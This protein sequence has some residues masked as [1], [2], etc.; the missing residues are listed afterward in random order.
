VITSFRVGAIFEIQDRATP[1]VDRLS[2]LM[3]ELGVATATVRTELQSISS[4]RIGSVTNRVSALAASMDKGGTAAAAMATAVVGG[5]ARM[6]ASLNTALG[7]ARAL[8]AQLTAAGRAGAGAGRGG[9]P[10]LPGPGG[11]GGGRHGPGPH[12]GRVGVHAGPGHVSAGGGD[13][14]ATGVGAWAVG[15]VLKESMDPMHQ[16]SQLRALGGD[17]LDPANLKAAMDRA[18]AT[19]TAVPGSGYAENLKTI[20]ELYSVVGLKGALALSPELAELDRVMALSGKGKEE[21]SG[22]ILTRASELMGQLTD[23]N[24]HEVDLPK[25]RN[26]LALAGKANLA[27]HG[28]VTPAEWLAFA[29][30][31]GPAAGSFTEEGF[32]TAVAVIQATSGNRA[33]TAMQAINRQFTGGKMNIDTAKELER[34][35]IAKPGD[36]EF[37]HGKVITKTGSMRTAV[38]QLQ[39][40]PLS[41]M[42]NTI[43]PALNAKGLTSVKDVQAEGYRMFG[44]GPAQR[45]MF[46]L[47]RGQ[48]QIK[49][50][51]A[52]AQAALAPG[53]A[54][55]SAQE[56]D[57]VQGMAAFT[58]AFNDMLGAIGGPTL[59][60]AIPGMNALTTLFNSVAAAASEH[61]QGAAIAGS[62]ASGAAAGAAI[63]LGIG[64]LGGPV[65]AG[66]G[67]LIGG[68]LGGLSGMIGSMSPQQRFGTL[69]GA[70]GGGAAGMVGGPIGMAFGALAGGALGAV[71]PG[72][73]P[74][75]QANAGQ[76]VKIDVGG[77]T[78]KA[79]T[80]DPRGLA[81]RIL[82]EINR[83]ISQGH[84]HNQGEAT[85]AA[86]SPYATGA[87]T[88]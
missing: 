9:A 63:G 4:V 74:S 60:A 29:K 84:L 49:Q 80:D 25:M 64:W 19:A 10:R 39:N 43:V 2:V 12:F 38:D 5:V 68:A 73:M 67:A 78:V 71:L 31:A 6:D 85:G 47:F 15:H 77:L 23:P 59:T 62:I 14:I 44:T 41:F 58:K 82:A 53:A 55:A 51:R 37:E 56:H 8:T 79:E 66:G 76:M 27:T 17:F 11:G 36:F 22:Y 87:V 69:S 32:L 45:L 54:F 86:S 88:P 52:R 57:P 75:G 34:L 13:A 72:L 61:K 40:D 21:G 33:G 24:T 20:G 48:E 18:R 3:R 42:V 30:Q 70:L 50:E 46:E 28:K 65:G 81:E 83:L 26:M 16:E 7:T 1:V 35:G